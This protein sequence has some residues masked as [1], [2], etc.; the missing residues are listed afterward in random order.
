MKY[1][2]KVYEVI[3]TILGA[4]GLAAFGLYDW[5]KYKIVSCGVCQGT[6]YDLTKI[7]S[8]NKD[9]PLCWACNGSGNRL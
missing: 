2:Y 5:A 4:I 3:I 7:V 1:V 6:G 8:N 9:T